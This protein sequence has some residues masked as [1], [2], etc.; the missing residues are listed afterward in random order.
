MW[1]SRRSRS[2]MKTSVPV[3]RRT[4]SRARP[5]RGSRASIP[6]CTS[7][8]TT[9]IRSASASRPSGPRIPSG[10]S[11]ARR[12]PPARHDLP[13]S[14]VA[15]DPG[16]HGRR[17][18]RDDRRDRDGLRDPDAT[19]ARPDGGVRLAPMASSATAELARFASALSLADVP[20]PVVG[21]VK[22]LVLDH[23]GCALGG[24]RTPLA[25]AAADVAVADRGSGA[26]VIGT[27]RRAAPGPAA[28]ANAMAANALDYDDTGATGHPGATVIP[29]ALALAEVGGRSG[30]ELMTAVVAGY[31]VWARILAGVQPSWERRVQVYGSGVTQTFGAAAAAAR[32]L[33]LGYEEMLCAFGLAGAFAPL[34]HEAKFGW[35]EDQLSWVKDNVA[36]PAEGGVRAALLAASG[37]RATRTILDG[38]RGLWRMLGSDRCDFDR[39]VH[40]LGT[41]WELLR[42]S[43]KPYPCCRWIH[44]TL[45]A[46]RD[47]VA[48]Q[49]LRPSDVRRVTVRSIEAFRAWF[50]SRRPA[51]MVDAQFSVPHAVAMAILDRPPPEWW[52]DAN[53]TDP[54]VLDLMDRVELKTDPAAQDTW[55]TIR[56]SARIPATVVIETPGGTVEAR[57]R[58]ARGGPDEPM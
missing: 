43:L 46:V 18:Q 27:R 13:R 38:D 19:P 58:H 16:A 31:E 42:V 57:R 7:A 51:S 36:W 4:R 49:G 32:L 56:H 6:R 45:D 25:R 17:L 47:L 29:A 24:S 26:T 28:F 30:T 3:A 15:P 41:D 35:N 9:P 23:L 11:R 1:R 8:S 40:D 39:M 37:F 44:S 33:G 10:S 22:R 34:P 52:W 14:A 48:G 5:Q 53:R 55:A 21:A 20:V 2:S 12:S 50:H 54:A